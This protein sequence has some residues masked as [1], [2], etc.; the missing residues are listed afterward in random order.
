MNTQQIVATDRW[1]MDHP[2]S[3]AAVVTYRWLDRTSTPDLDRLKRELEAD[4]RERWG[5]ATKAEINADP[6]L[7]AY[8]R[9][10]K[11]F[12]QN[13]HVAMQIRSIAQKGKT[14]PDRNP[15][16]EVMFMTE[17]TTGVLAAAQ[18]AD[19]IQ[20]P[21]TVDSATG[22]ET[23]IRYDGV[24]ERCKAGDQLMRDGAGAV[25]TSIAQGP[26][27]YGLVGE[28]TTAVTYCFYFPEGVAEVVIAESVAYLDTCVRAFSPNAVANEPM[29]VSADG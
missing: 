22:D 9:H 11:R 19:L 15:A 27:A 5:S 25:L 6:T 1:R 21:I 13:Y 18:D 3:R 28:G 7:A 17:L 2:G 10:D 23:Y 24:E 29:I 16:I 12:G 8:E 20:F 4:L 14:I 26:T